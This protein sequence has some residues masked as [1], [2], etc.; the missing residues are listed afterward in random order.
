MRD[1]AEKPNL[2][3]SVEEH[4]LEAQLSHIRRSVE[5]E[6]AQKAAT[7]VQ[8]RLLGVKGHLEQLLSMQY[9]SD[10]EGLDLA[11]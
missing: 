3:H 4:L 2:L 5:S 11:R 6:R 8:R 1:V 9:G 10:S 7:E